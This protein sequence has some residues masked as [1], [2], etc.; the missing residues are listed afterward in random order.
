MRNGAVI[1]G[2]LVPDM[3]IVVMWAS[4]KLS[5]TPEAVIWRDLYWRPEWQSA[6]A[7]TNSLPIYL[8]L[9]VAAAGLG[10][11]LKPISLPAGA[12]PDPFD[13]RRG[14]EWLVAILAFSVAAMVHVATDF[15]LHVFDGHPTFWPFS[16]WVFQSPVSYWDPRYFGDYVSFIELALAAG[17]IVILWRRFSSHAIRGALVLAAVSYIAV[18]H[19]WATSFG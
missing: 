13:T 11:R 7:V 17:L 16:G 19:H 15:P 5:G 3:S 9:A 6:A 2:G 12:P 10:A 14:V 4:A 8:A 1:A 18:A